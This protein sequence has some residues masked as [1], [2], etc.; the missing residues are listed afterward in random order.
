MVERTQ[1]EDSV[2][3][4]VEKWELSCVTNVGPDPA[5]RRAELTCRL[6][7]AG[8]RID[9]LHVVAVFGE[10]RGMHAFRPADVEDA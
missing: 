7:V 4:G 6:H 9:D 5:A 3:T 1:H 10:P 8:Y 2:E